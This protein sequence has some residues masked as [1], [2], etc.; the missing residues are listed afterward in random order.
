[1]GKSK[2]KAR[3]RK[4]QKYYLHLARQ[5]KNKTNESITDKR[6][7][8]LI[9]KTNKH[10]PVKNVIHDDDDVISLIASDNDFE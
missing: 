9:D 8:V 6:R 3:S 1:M 4:Q 5:Q 10:E 2:L 7:V